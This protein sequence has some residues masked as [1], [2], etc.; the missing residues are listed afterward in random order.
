MFPLS[1]K[2]LDINEHHSEVKLFLYKKYFCIDSI[3][4]I[5]IR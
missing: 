5:Y 4:K 1:E 2:K 3:E